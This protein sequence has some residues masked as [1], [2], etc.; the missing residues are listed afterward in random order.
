MG[1]PEVVLRRQ[2]ARSNN[3]KK[4][5]R[6]GKREREIEKNEKGAGRSAAET[7][8]KLMEPDFSLL[9]A[10]KKN[11]GMKKRKKERREVENRKSERTGPPS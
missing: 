6:G 11:A 1:M 10:I 3:I 8:E 4:E 7:H 2:T 5:G 9:R